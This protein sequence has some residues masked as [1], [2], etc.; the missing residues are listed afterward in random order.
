MRHHITTALALQEKEPKQMLLEQM[1]QQ[2]KDLFHVNAVFVLQVSN[3]HQ[4]P[5]Q[6]KR[7][8]CDMLMNVTLC[9]VPSRTDACMYF[10]LRK[11]ARS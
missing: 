2:V 9:K 5:E 7:A 3:Y 6:A 10:F 8:L 1:T 4:M 11:E